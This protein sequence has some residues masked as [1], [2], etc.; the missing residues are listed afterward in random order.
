M[1]MEFTHRFL[2]RKAFWDLFLDNV[3]AALLPKYKNRDVIESI[4]TFN[5]YS[6]VVKP[7][8][9]FCG[10][11]TA[12][13]HLMLK[14]LHHHSLI[15]MPFS[16]CDILVWQILPLSLDMFFVGVSFFAVSCEY[17]QNGVCSKYTSP[18]FHHLLITTG[19][20]IQHY[21]WSCAS[22]A[23]LCLKKASLH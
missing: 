22:Q 20:S 17:Y 9:E 6:I 19:S 1:W 5:S 12:C 13:H 21:V 15:N 3:G 8:F 14:L 10:Q 11:V 23:I 16:S 2:Y 18:W 4:G 7:S